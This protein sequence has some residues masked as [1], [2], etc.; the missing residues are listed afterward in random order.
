MTRQTS[1]LSKGE[2]QVHAL[3][4]A[5]VGFSIGSILEQPVIQNLT[6]DLCATS[7]LCSLLQ[8]LRAVLEAPCTWTPHDCTPLQATI[9]L[10]LS[11]LLPVVLSPLE[12]AATLVAVLEGIQDGKQRSLLQAVVCRTSLLQPAL[13]ELLLLLATTNEA[14]SSKPAPL[15]PTTTVSLRLTTKTNSGDLVHLPLPEQAYQQDINASAKDSVVS[16]VIPA[17]AKACTLRLLCSGDVQTL[18]CTAKLLPSTSLDEADTSAALPLAHELKDVQLPF[19]VDGLLNGMP[20]L[21][22][23]L[24]KHIPDALLASGLSIKCTFGKQYSLVAGEGI[25]QYPTS[26]HFWNIAASSKLCP[27]NECDMSTQAELCSRLKRLEQCTAA[28]PSLKAFV[29]VLDAVQLPCDSLVRPDILEQITSFVRLLIVYSAKHQASTLS[30]EEMLNAIPGSDVCGELLYELLGTAMSPLLFAETALQDIPAVVLCCVLTYSKAMSMHQLHRYAVG[31]ACCA[32]EQVD[33]ACVSPRTWLKPSRSATTGKAQLHRLFSMLHVPDFKSMAAAAHLTVP[34]TVWRGSACAAT[35]LCGPDGAVVLQSSWSSPIHLAMPAHIANTSQAIQPAGIL[36]TSAKPVQL[37]HIVPRPSTWEIQNAV[38]CT[39]PQHT[40]FGS[41]AMFCTP[42]LVQD[43]LSTCVAA[44]IHATEDLNDER[45]TAVY[46]A[47]QDLQQR[48]GFQAALQRELQQIAQSKD[49]TATVSSQNLL[50]Q[51]CMLQWKPEAAQPLNKYRVHALDY[52]LGSATSQT[53]PSV[54]DRMPLTPTHAVVTFLKGLKQ[55]KEAKGTANDPAHLLTCAVEVIDQEALLHLKL[56]G[57]ATGSGSPRQALPI[58][59]ALSSSEV[60]DSD[61]QPIVQELRMFG[62]LTPNSGSKPVMA[63]ALDVSFEER[64]AQRFLEGM[65]FEIVYLGDGVYRVKLAHLDAGKHQLQINADGIQLACIHVS[66]QGAASSASASPRHKPA[67]DIVGELGSQELAARVGSSSMGQPSLDSFM[68]G[69]PTTLKVMASNVIKMRGGPGVETIEL[70]T[71]PQGTESL[72]LTGAVAASAV[73]VEDC[74]QT[75]QTKV[76]VPAKYTWVLLD[77]TEVAKYAIEGLGHIPGWVCLETFVK[78]N[79]EPSTAYRVVCASGGEEVYELVQPLV[80]RSEVDLCEPEARAEKAPAAVAEAQNVKDAEV[81]AVAAPAEME[82][83]FVNLAAD[84]S[85]EDDDIEEWDEDDDDSA[86]EGEESD[87]ND[88]DAEVNPE[89]EAAGEMPLVR[90]QLQRVLEVAQE[91]EQQVADETSKVAT[92]PTARAVDASISTQTST[93]PVSRLELL[94]Q[95]FQLALNS[96]DSSQFLL[97]TDPLFDLQSA[98][99]R[100]VPSPTILFAMAEESDAQSGQS[101]MTSKVVESMQAQRDLDTSGLKVAGNAPLIV[102]VENP[103]VALEPDDVDYLESCFLV[104]TSAAEVH[105]LTLSTVLNGNLCLVR[106]CKDI[107]VSTKN[108]SFVSTASKLRSIQNSELQSLLADLPE[109]TATRTRKLVE[110]TKECMGTLPLTLLQ[111]EKTARVLRCGT[112]SETLARIELAAFTVRCLNLFLRLRNPHPRHDVQETVEALIVRDPPFDAQHNEIIVHGHHYFQAW[113]VVAYNF[114][115]A[116]SDVEWENALSLLQSI[117]YTEPQVSHPGGVGLVAEESFE[118]LVAT[119]PM[120]FAEELSSLLV[121][122]HNSILSAIPKVSQPSRLAI[123]FNILTTWEASAISISSDNRRVLRHWLASAMN[124]P[125]IKETLRNRLCSLNA[126]SIADDWLTYTQA[127]PIAVVDGAQLCPSLFK[128]DAMIGVILKE[129]VRVRLDVKDKLCGV[130]VAE[131]SAVTWS[132]CLHKSSDLEDETKSLRLNANVTVAMV[133][134]FHEIALSVPKS[135]DGAAELSDFY[136]SDTESDAEVEDD[137][138]IPSSTATP[139]V[140][141]TR[142]RKAMD[143]ADKQRGKVME[144]ERSRAVPDIFATATTEMAPV[145]M[146]L[147][148]AFDGNES[149]ETLRCIV[150]PQALLQDVVC[151]SLSFAP[152]A[153]PSGSNS[154][155][156]VPKF[157]TLHESC[158]TATSQAHPT[159]WATLLTLLT[160]HRHDWTSGF[161]LYILETVKVLLKSTDKPNQE[162]C[163]KFRALFL[164]LQEHG[165]PV[166]LN[167]QTETC[168]VSY[169]QVVCSMIQL[170]IEANLLQWPQGLSITKDFA[171]CA[172]F[173]LK[174]AYNL[175]KSAEGILKYMNEVGQIL[176]RDSEDGITA[177]QLFKV[178]LDTA[179]DTLA[180]VW[181][182]DTSEFSFDSQSSDASAQ[183]SFDEGET[184]TLLKDGLQ[185]HKQDKS[186]NDTDFAVALSNIIDLAWTLY[187]ASEEPTAVEPEI[188]DHFVQ[189]VTKLQEWW[190]EPSPSTAMLKEVASLVKKIATSLALVTEPIAA[191]LTEKCS[192]K[193]NDVILCCENHGDGITRAVSFCHTCSTSLC[194]DCDVF[195]HLPAKRRTHEREPIKAPIQA[196]SVHW[197]ENTTTLSIGQLVLSLSKLKT[198]SYRLQ[199]KR[200]ATSG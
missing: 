198:G 83:V 174:N 69:Q 37:S 17:R 31:T 6:Q 54:E 68:F 75:K 129:K 7:E 15:V 107:K 4:V 77:E 159:S 63:S 36:L 98:S 85:D 122:L 126:D 80:W 140:C 146:P 22:V 18:S 96:W 35:P 64:R 104:R 23:S 82:R 125:L 123:L 124:L 121:S 148:F 44:R 21:H 103:M 186:I 34:E 193:T 194:K 43:Q 42:K 166:Y 118:T 14:S 135:E 116:S 176:L 150:V 117:L 145:A 155:T 184:Q 175:G 71:I 163:D 160:T 139:T 143:K 39:D 133:E 152:A 168:T 165:L 28:D 12:R 99:L 189:N 73:F 161:S 137:E 179:Q 170:L 130:C 19:E 127:R 195:W 29:G 131:S 92:A 144:Q 51:A 151:F 153:E 30:S 9:E 187:S 32:A 134:R 191:Q 27:T 11:W 10:V 50:N 46:C 25:G 109:S 138:A 102:V 105:K 56:L 200:N 112:R 142:K 90:G 158:V 164:E 141:T 136:G 26:V 78:D 84:D 101:D 181:T 45:A 38:A 120:P 154:S 172:K 113:T 177:A 40:Q 53:S 24:L 61:A 97:S 128:D 108:K 196:T 132:L 180:T 114:R 60:S 162:Q 115:K 178:L 147:E 48:A 33:E 119:C 106:D 72:S 169:C 183:T 3:R 16:I 157:F 1:E 171:S 76:T 94:A 95:R 167:A 66:V 100:K 41:L 74:V 91:Q 49:V 2:Y 173:Y 111:K 65:R 199:L 8:R 149:T 86:G 79:E 188:F 185:N 62:L 20:I 13:H 47:E 190:R 110:F 81:H 58:P 156:A 89:D 55:V 52:L 192:P 59:V 88:S 197:T 5:R 87:H 57:Q 70:G 67:T 182:V 93:A